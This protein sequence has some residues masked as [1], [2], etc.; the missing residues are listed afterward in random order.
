M[1]DHQLWLEES[2]DNLRSLLLEALQAGLF[3]APDTTWRQHESSEI[4]YFADRVF[5]VERPAVLVLAREVTN[6]M[7][8]ESVDSDYRSYI[9]VGAVLG[10]SVQLGR[11]R[12]TRARRVAQTEFGEH[13][14]GVFTLDGA[15]L[16]TLGSPLSWC[17]LVGEVMNAQMP[18]PFVQRKV[19]NNCMEIN[20]Y[21]TPKCTNCGH[22][23]TLT[24]K[25]G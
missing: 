22:P 4:L 7:V 19:C 18:A 20:E 17:R 11:A 13:Y 12:E 9:V 10:S 23:L 16:V 3:I 5:G 1:D 24:G 21:H 15:I 14:W 8:S 25:L 6:E 2:Y